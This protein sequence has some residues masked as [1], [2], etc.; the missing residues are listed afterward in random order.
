VENLH[1][2]QVEVYQEAARQALKEWA[3]SAPLEPMEDADTE[4]IF[5]E[6]CVSASCRSAPHWKINLES[7]VGPEIQARAKV[8]FAKYHPTAADES[9]EE[10]EEGGGDEDGEM[11]EDGEEQEEGEGGG[12]EEDTE[13]EDGEVASATDDKLRD[14]TGEDSAPSKATVAHKKMPVTT[15]NKKRGGGVKGNGNKNSNNNSNN[16]K[17]TARKK[18]TTAKAGAPNTRVQ[19]GRGKGGASRGGGR[20]GGRGGGGGSSTA[21]NN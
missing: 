15:S 14:S 1:K 7:V 13:N 18:A 10:G 3:T 17:T 2:A 19:G 8:A 12:G 20:R 5:V 21:K 9:L 4:D 6:R 16:N 11:G